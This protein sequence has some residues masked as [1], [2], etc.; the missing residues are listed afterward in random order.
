[1]SDQNEELPNLVD[2]LTYMRQNCEDASE[3]EEYEQEWREKF[4]KDT[5][6]MELDNESMLSDFYETPGRT[7]AIYNFGG[8]CKGV[9]IVIKGG[10]IQRALLT[11]WSF[12]LIPIPFGMPKECKAKFSEPGI[13]RA[14]CP[15][16]SFNN[17]VNIEME[18]RGNALG[19]DT[20]TVEVLPVQEGGQSSFLHEFWVSVR[21]DLM[22]SLAAADNGGLEAVG[23]LFNRRTKKERQ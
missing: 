17:Q 13:L 15:D 10:A 8:Q 18:A 11:D 22:A 21:N 19:V 14:D 2:G 4:S 9:S 6:D 12:N 5:V 20:F 23:A 16:F 3:L 7:I 1:M